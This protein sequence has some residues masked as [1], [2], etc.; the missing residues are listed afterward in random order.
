MSLYTDD[1]ICD[2]CIHAYLCEECGKFEYCKIDAI[3]NYMNGKCEQREI[4][5]NDC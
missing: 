1:K 5:Y 3:K 2:K 4:N